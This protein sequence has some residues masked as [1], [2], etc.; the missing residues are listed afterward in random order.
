LTNSNWPVEHTKL[1]ASNERA[2]KIARQ[3]RYRKKKG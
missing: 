2:Q 1:G 3:A